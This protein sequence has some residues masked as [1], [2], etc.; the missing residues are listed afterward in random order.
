MSIIVNVNILAKPGQ[1]QDLARGIAAAQKLALVES[2][3][4]GATVLRNVEDAR[5]IIIHEVWDTRE[6]Y[7]TFNK[8]VVTTPE[9]SSLFAMIEGAPSYSY[10]ETVG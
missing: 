2:Q 7:E 4:H 5:Q 1:E 6:A 8:R 9:V 10:F 3:N